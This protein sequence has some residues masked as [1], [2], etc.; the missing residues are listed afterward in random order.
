M[1]AGCAYTMTSKDI[2]L[3]ASQPACVLM[4]IDQA[5]GSVAVTNEGEQC[6]SFH[7]C[8]RTTDGAADAPISDW[9]DVHPVSGELQPQ[10]PAPRIAAFTTGTACADL[11]S[12]WQH[13]ASHSASLS[14]SGNLQCRVSL[15]EQWP[16]TGACA[17]K[18]WMSL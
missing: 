9:L 15:E 12:E 4:Q 14:H 17:C 3:C 1:T 18:H 11:L 5:S 8:G 16:K 13:C 6:I 10:V 7:V 2:E